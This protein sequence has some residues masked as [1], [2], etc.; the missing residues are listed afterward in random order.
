[1]MLVQTTINNR[2]LT[3]IAEEFD[4][5]LLLTLASFI[6]DI[7]EIGKP[8]LQILFPKT[9]ETVPRMPKYKR[10]IKKQVS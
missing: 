7:Q 8:N 4:K 10:K 3:Y 2:L 6:Q 1:M 9:S 5:F